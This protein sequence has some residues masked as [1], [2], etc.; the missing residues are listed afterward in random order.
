MILFF[1]NRFGN[2]REIA[3]PETMD[4]ARNEITKFLDEH[5][6][7]SY[8]LRVN[9]AKGDLWIDVGSHMEFFWIHDDS[10][11]LT[12]KDFQEVM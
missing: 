10:R 5:N 12:L 6:F 4:I 7:K 9:E 2:K 8:Y 11:S 1:E 3:Q